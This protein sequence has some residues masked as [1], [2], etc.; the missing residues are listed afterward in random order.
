MFMIQFNNITKVFLFG[1]HVR[2]VL[3]YYYIRIIPTYI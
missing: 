3:D 2:L 1:M